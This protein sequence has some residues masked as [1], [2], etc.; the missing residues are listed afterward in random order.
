[1]SSLLRSSLLQAI[2]ST[3][4]KLPA[5]TF[6][7]PSTTF[8]TSYILPSRPANSSAVYS[9]PIDIKHSTHKS[10]TAFLRISEKEGLIRLKEGRGKTDS[11][12]LTVLGVTSDH[13]DVNSHRS[14]K[15]LADVEEKR[16]RMEAREA[17][18]NNQNFNLAVIELWKPYQDSLPLFTEIKQK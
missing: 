17:K 7:M 4:S 5:S 14:Y 11:G 9:T 18:E 12:V 16:A 1:M 3:L 13:P 2:E 15:T 10:L 8:Y 6:P